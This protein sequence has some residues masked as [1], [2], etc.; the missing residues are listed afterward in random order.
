MIVDRRDPIVDSDD[1]ESNNQDQG[2]DSHAGEMTGCQI[3]ILGA[4]LHSFNYV[5]YLRTDFFLCNSSP[6][7]Y[8]SLYVYS[9]S[10]GASYRAHKLLQKLTSM[11][12]LI[13]HPATFELVKCAEELLPHIPTFQNLN[14][15]LIM[16]DDVLDFACKGLLSILQNS[17]QLNHL[18]IRSPITLSAYDEEQDNWTLEP[19]PPSFSTHL[20][21]IDLWRFLGSDDELHVVKVLLRT[22]PVLEKMRFKFF[23]LFMNQIE[24]YEGIKKF[25]KASPNCEI[26]LL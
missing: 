21:T 24:L 26:G 1:D 6:L 13:I 15:L 9:T 11:K 2:V 12:L 20:K 7:V 4:N 14:H 22:A 17:P 23:A 3:M 19:I 16:G 25:P 8:A 5:G 10:R 18:E